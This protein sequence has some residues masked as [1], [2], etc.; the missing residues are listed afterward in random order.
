LWY[1]DSHH[2]IVRIS[3]TAIGETE[4]IEA[5]LLHVRAKKDVLIE[6]PIAMIVAVELYLEVVCSRLV[7]I[8]RHNTARIELVVMEVR[9]PAV[10]DDQPEAH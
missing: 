3:R 9:P 10:W 4:A 2:L 7:S 6:H 8:Y 5:G 1:S